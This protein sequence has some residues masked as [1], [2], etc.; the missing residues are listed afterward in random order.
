MAFIGIHLNYKTNC[1]FICYHLLQG[2]LAEKKQDVCFWGDFS[3]SNTHRHIICRHILFALY[4]ICFYIYWESYNPD[5]IQYFHS[6]ISVYYSMIRATQY[7]PTCHFTACH[8]PVHSLIPYL[9]CCSE[10]S[11]CH[12][13]FL[14]SVARAGIL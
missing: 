5:I 1:I 8:Q 11:C 12:S 7:H 6:M 10:L 3:M 9:Q 13:V 4:L 14:L 2:W